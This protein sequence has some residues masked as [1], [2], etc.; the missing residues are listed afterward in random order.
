MNRPAST[1]YSHLDSLAID[2][3]FLGPIAY[4]QGL[5]IKGDPASFL[6]KDE[7]TM[8]MEHE[9]EVRM[10]LAWTIL[11]SL[12]GLGVETHGRWPHNARK[13]RP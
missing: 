13:E 10:E 9:K 2:S 6:W 7:R 8:R 11:D 1:I 4:S 12:C 3:K 5:S